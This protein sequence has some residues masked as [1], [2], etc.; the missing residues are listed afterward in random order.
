[1]TTPDS[2]LP[3]HEIDVFASA[4][5]AGNPVAVIHNADSISSQRMQNIAHWTN[6]SETTFLLEP[7]DPTAD[8]RVRIFT[9]YSELPFA[10]HPTLGTCRAWLQNGG[11]PKSQGEIVQECEAGLIPIRQEQERLAFAAPPMKR[12]GQPTPAE[13]ARA[14]A[15]LGLTDEQVVDVE[16]VDNGPGWIGVLVRDAQTVLDVQV[17]RVDQSPIDVVVVGPYP[18]G[19]ECQL[20]LRAFFG[21]SASALLEDPVTGSANAS[22]AQWLSSS[23]RI[24]FP[25]VAAQGT[26]LGRQ[27]R[28][29][30]S[31]ADGEIWVGGHT[32]VQVSGTI[33]I[34][35]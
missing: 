1:M 11:S 27:G 8:Y 32:I 3:F 17:V 4:G 18:V 16:W 30:L 33:N 22:V 35:T 13:R 23:G 5:F 26:Q 9:P 7:A 19:S 12:S 34:P 29:F 20:E 24:S 15:V 28:A 6:F 21:E 25:Y 14:I 2:A 31:R 10:G